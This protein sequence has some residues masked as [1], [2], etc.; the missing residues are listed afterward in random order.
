M[1]NSLPTF[2]YK[3]F[4]FLAS[5]GSPVLQPHNYM[6]MSYQH[7]ESNNLFIKQSLVISLIDMTTV[8]IKDI[9]PLI[10]KSQIV[11][12]FTGKEV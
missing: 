8:I 9:S 10:I 11:L 2:G 7:I 3:G 1:S 5:K 4:F 12:R 6:L